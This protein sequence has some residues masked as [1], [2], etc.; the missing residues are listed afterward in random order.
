MVFGQCS[1]QLEQNNPVCTGEFEI[2][3]RPAD[4]S[5]EGEESSEESE[6]TSELSVSISCPANPKTGTSV[7]CTASVSGAKQDEKLDYFWSLDGGAGTG[8]KDNTY[9]WKGKQSGYYEVS[10]EVFSQ[11]RTAK[12]TIRVEVVDSET[13]EDEEST[14]EE[15]ASTGTNDVSSL[16]SDLESFLK[17]AGVKN[18]NPAKL[19]VAGTGVSALIAIWMIT[20]N[21]SGVPMEKLEKAL[22]QWRWREGQKVP[23]PDS[24][25]KKK[26][27]GKRPEKLPEKPS[28]KAPQTLPEGLK[29]EKPPTAQVT[30]PEEK[31]AD[32]G[33]TA[34]ASAEFS[35]PDPAAASPPP[36]KTVSGE[37][38]EERAERLVDDTE[39]NRDAVDKTMAGL[40]KKL[41]E[42]PKPVKDS[43]FW[44]QKV[45]PKLKKLDE[46]GIES[47]SGKLK[48]FLR[49][50]KELLQVR[51]KVDADLSFYNK[52]DREGIVYLERVLH[53]G[54]EVIKKAH[55]QFITDPAIAAAKWGLPKE[56]AAAA[57]KILKQ[58]Q[59]DIEN[60]FE[61]I[62][63]L[64]RKMAENQFKASKRHLAP[65]L[66]K[67]YY[68]GIRHNKPT[69]FH[70]GLEKIQ[71]AIKKVK[72]AGAWAK[73]QLGKV[74]IGL[75]DTR[76]GQE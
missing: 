38:W 27:P 8:S 39:D 9:T 37:T 23:K 31:P 18:I 10:V 74:F 61:G 75:R 47:K 58:H 15:S 5:E 22:G 56:Q 50:T 35:E 43:E 45:A 67:E 73:K 53:G 68:D 14:S 51:K 63:K 55:Q 13:S 16:V 52:K 66:N 26:Q 2:P 76:P 7:T 54:K 34:S 6:D 28:E 69:Q 30:I 4:A 21:R 29:S 44:K 65:D 1:S 36:S 3:V 71:P 62:K 48:E 24:E 72:E 70:K 20:Q 19:A 17:A 59:T 57:E 32:E 41:E 60:M 33:A 64:P 42:V 40:K 49:I 12:K 25:G 46:M 11:D